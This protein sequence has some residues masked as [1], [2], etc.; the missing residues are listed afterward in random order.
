MRPL[1]NIV[2]VRHFSP[3]GSVEVE[4]LLDAVRPKVVA[5]EMP[6]DTEHLIEAMG[7]SDAAPPLA[8]LSYKELAGHRC[9]FYPMARHSPEWAIIRWGVRNGVPVKCLD[10]PSAHYLEQ[11]EDDPLMAAAKAASSG[12]VPD[13]GVLYNEEALTRVAAHQGN[14]SVDAWWELTFE[15]S[16]EGQYIPLTWE[17]SGQLRE[18]PYRNKEWEAEILLRER[19]MRGVLKDII[20][21]GVSPDEIVAVCGAAHSVALVDGLEAMSA[22]ERRQMLS[23]SVK[24]AL[25]PYS[26]RR[27]SSKGG[28]G[29]GSEAPRFWE[30]M[31]ESMKEGRSYADR[32]AS[33]VV[34]YLRG[35]GVSRSTAHVIEAVRLAVAL[36]AVGE[37]PAP[38]LEDLR[39]S[40]RTVMSEGDVDMLKKAFEAVEIGYAIGTTPV[41]VGSTPLQDDFRRLIRKNHLE[42]YLVDEDK[43]VKGI[44]N[45]DFLDLRGP[46]NEVVRS[47]MPKEMA[48]DRDL[49]VSIMLHRLRLLSLGIMRVREREMANAGKRGAVG[50]VDIFAKELRKV[51][52][53]AGYMETWVVRWEPGMEVSLAE[54]MLFGSSLEIAAAAALS[55]LISMSQTADKASQVIAESVRADF[56]DLFV[57]AMEHLKELIA[58][59]RDFISLNDTVWNL[60]SATRVYTQGMDLDSVQ[61]PMRDAWDRGVVVFPATWYVAAEAAKDVSRAMLDFDGAAFEVEEYGADLKAWLVSLRKCVDDFDTRGIIAGTALG[62]LLRHRAVTDVD[63]EDLLRKRIDPHIDMADRAGFFEG[64]LLSGTG[65]VVAKKNVWRSLDDLVRGLAKDEFMAIVV[66]LRLALGSLGEGDKAKVTRHLYEIWGFAVQEEKPA[67]DVKLSQEDTEKMLEELEGLEDLGI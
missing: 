63:F 15:H 27:L 35:I 21:T 44:T 34:Q 45:A 59:E 55:E 58:H 19:H 5:L 56:E 30:M 3:R 26:Y 46:M 18:L 22:S 4:A 1:A 40:I 61:E 9:M 66:P 36:A 47:K 50:R 17:L 10:I 49:Q 43:I 65:P 67:L 64:L 57:Q 24:S 2:G 38:L 60:K 62:L 12:F 28:Y 53:E 42:P 39:D 41:G 32:Y 20:S 6:I 14:L 25:M 29:A 37:R 48:S 13:P 11:D 23:S 33:E 52:G 16:S 8:V 51:S 54:G 7:R 31:Y